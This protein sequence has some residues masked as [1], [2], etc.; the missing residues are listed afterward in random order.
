MP[1][2]ESL[3]G[4]MLAD[5]FENPKSTS[6][7]S[8]VCLNLFYTNVPRQSHG[9]NCCFRAI[10]DSDAKLQVINKATSKAYVRPDEAEGWLREL[11][12]AYQT[13]LEARRTA[14]A[15]LQRLRRMLEEKQRP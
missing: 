12:K 5:A 11:E 8:T 3:P 13:E 6:L 15:E 9:E 2:P 4:F 7:D 10:L 1:T 14:E